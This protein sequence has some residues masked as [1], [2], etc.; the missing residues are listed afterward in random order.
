MDLKIRGSL[1]TQVY[2]ILA[3]YVDA[4]EKKKTIDNIILS[5][6]GNVQ[7]ESKN[8]SFMNV[9]S[10][11]ENVGLGME[12]NIVKEPHI[13]HKNTKRIIENFNEVSNFI[14]LKPTALSYKFDNVVHVRGKDKQIVSVDGYVKLINKFKKKGIVTEKNTILLGDDPKMI[15]D[16]H[17]KTGLTKPR[18]QHISSD[19]YTCLNAKV[20]IGSPSMFFLSNQ[21]WRKERQVFVTDEKW[22]DGLARLTAM[23]N[24]LIDING[25][26]ENFENMEWI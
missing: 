24:Y 8:F 1:G 17:K 2:K 26:I 14:K 5:V 20:V 12:K 22:N 3:G 13:N 10:I 9:L 6:G 7:P 15:F 19:W 25:I 11:P 21:F 16:I 23:G 18:E 4:I